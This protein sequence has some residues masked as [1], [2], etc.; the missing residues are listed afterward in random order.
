MTTNELSTGAA[1]LPGDPP[2]FRRFMSGTR[3]IDLTGIDW[4]AIPDHPLQPDVLRVLIHMQ[5][6]ESHT[7]VFPRTIFSRRALADEYIGPFL[8]CWLY[9]EGMH[10]RALARFLHCAGQKISPAV[11][12]RTTL[13]DRVDRLVTGAIAAAWP[14][15]LALH[16]TWAAAH[17]ST[18][19]QAYHRLIQSNDHPI[20]NELLRRIMR[21]EARHLA[22]YLWQSEQLLARPRVARI[23]RRIMERFY[24]PVGTSHQPDAASRWVSGFLFDGD[25]GRAAVRQVDRTI[26]KLPGF[27]GATLLNPW[28]E[29][30]VYN[31]PAAKS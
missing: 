1:V 28:L 7:V 31:S 29:R 21:D 9:E 30:H 27:R 2:Q 25:E 23:V 14:D 18:T 8:I 11:M 13:R 12:G 10:G 20:L 22:F 5:D 17:E 15:F 16:M 26:A 4:D 3:P 19:I 24:T 6:V